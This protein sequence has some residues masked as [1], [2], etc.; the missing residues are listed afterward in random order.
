VR[1]VLMGVAASTLLLVALYRLEGF[2]RLVFAIDAAVL[3]SF[4]VGARLAITS[5]D[6]YLRRRRGAGRPVLIYG[7]GIGGALLVRALLEDGS[8]GLVPVG[9]IDDDRAK[10]RLRL[11]GVPVVGTFD[12]LDGL[13][14][15]MEIGEL[16][17][18]IKAFDRAKL[19]QVAA[20]CRARGVS[21]RAMR[22][23]LEEVGPIPAIRHA[24]GR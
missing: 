5:L 24:Q 9:I 1:G 14:E 18:S 8:F 17:V 15:R 11:E 20:V 10:R 7:A 2:S 6:E 4:L 13:I 22:F 23:A 3:V 16:V 19:A 21:I 12:D